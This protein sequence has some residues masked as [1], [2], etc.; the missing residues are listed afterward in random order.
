ML[1]LV[2][3][4]LYLHDFDCCL[5]LELMWP[6]AAYTSIQLLGAL[7]PDSPPTGEADGDTAVKGSQPHFT[8]GT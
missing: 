4:A 6:A 8:G 3:H 2:L 1:N 5:V 7:L